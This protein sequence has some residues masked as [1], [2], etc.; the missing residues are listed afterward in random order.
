MH[1]ARESTGE[2]WSAVP[3]GLLTAAVGVLLW[4]LLQPRTPD[5]AAQVYRVNLFRQ[6][7]FGVWDERWYGGHDLPG[8]SLT[9]PAL[10][11]WLG[12]RTVG[13]L[14]ALGS[15]ALF[16]RIAGRAYGPGARWGAMWFALAAV[17]DVWIGRV[18]FALGVC[19]ALGAALA[20]VRGRPTLAVLLGAL[21]AAGSPVAGVLLALAG[22]SLALARRSP[23]AAMLLAGPALLVVGAL[24]ALFPEGGFEPFPTRSFIATAAVGLGFLWLLPRRRALERVG[25]LVYL[26]VCV[27]G[28]LV[29]TPMGS[30]V[31]RYGVLLAGPLLL[32][33]VLAERAGR[34]IATACVL[35]GIAVWTFWG[36]VRETVAVAHNSSTEAAYYVPVERF[37]AAHGGSTV[38]VEVPFTRGHWEAAW[39][40][41]TV[42]LARGWE[43]QLDERYD[44][45][46]LSRGLTA[47]TYLQWLRREAVSYVALADTPLDPSSAREGEL[48]RAGLGYLHEVQRSAHW[49]IYRV[50]GGAPLLEGPGRL[51]E[52]G[53]DSF[54]ISARSAG[55]FLLRVRYTRYFTVTA[56]SACLG[57]APGGWTAVR[58][59][60]PGTVRV[61]A[62]FSLGRALGLDGGGCSQLG[63]A[64]AGAASS[65]PRSGG[66]RAARAHSVRSTDYQWFV[67][68]DAPPPSIAQENRRRGTGAWR[69]AGP[70]GPLGGVA[71]G[72]I[73]GY[74]A[75]EAIVAG[76]VQRVYVNAPGTPRVQIAIYRMGWYGG[77]GGRLVLRSDALP[78]VRQPPCTHRLA[79]GLTECRWHPTLSFPIPPGLVSGVYVVKL[80]GARGAQRDCLF[81][82]R[83]PRPAPLLVEIPTATYEAYNAW[84]GDS[85]YPGGRRV[86][87]TGSTQGVEVS[88]DR[89]YDSQTGAGQF[90]IREVA[91]V[92]FLERYG[93]P[94]SYTTIAAIDQQPEQVR[95][96]R[97]LLDVGHSE[98]WSQRAARAFAGARDS[99][100]SLIFLSSDTM[101]WRVRLAPAT[102]ASSQAGEADHVIVA[103]KQEARRDPDRAQPSGLFPLGGAGLVG[104]AYNGCITPRVPQ[105][106][107]PVYRYYAWVPAPALRPAWLFAGSGVSAATRI[108]GIVG[109]ELDQRTLASPPGT[110]VIGGGSPVRCLPEDE[111]SPVRG[112]LA[113]STLYTAPSGALVFAS[114]TLGWGYGLSPVPQASPDAPRRPDRRVVAITRNLLAR[115]LAPARPAR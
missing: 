37:V 30:N 3:W 61:A 57:S 74:V 106:G 26:A 59:G 60:A 100:T 52:L 58:A 109:Y 88:Y 42:S 93:Y 91:M 95:G 69:L 29:D 1:V 5:L 23:R 94:V 112:G 115:V 45:V 105:P 104:S 97:G 38:R 82:V 47:A 70:P 28:L 10:A 14:A 83:S 15:T 68:L 13:A 99:G 17:G 72:R 53:H 25:A 64:A 9:F 73:E 49:R 67:P 12:I 31:E 16:E 65:K 63:A 98:Y 76:Q 85:L 56:G 50:L 19:L 7:G 92:R 86:G 71:N 110:R 2:P 24:A 54:A 102:G 89:P 48:I 80:Q 4:V 114:G 111:P 6:E 20:M 87:I 46:L 33:C 27:G 51:S 77:R 107:P 32:C 66:Q 75:H 18:T 55:S 40:A 36:P 81:V 44:G 101:A 96:V 8:Y 62:R 113:Q 108:P 34:Q 35:V 103:Y 41:P 79:T 22:V 39:L 21:C 84:G 43:K 78:V 11:A 90:F